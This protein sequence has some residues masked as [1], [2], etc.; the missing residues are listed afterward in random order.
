MILVV[1]GAG[2]I[3][4]HV[5]KLLNE[6]SYETVVYDSLI[7]GHRRFAKWGEMGLGDLGSREQLRLCFE[8]YPIEAV[9][10]FGGFTYVGESVSDPA[11]YYRNNLINTF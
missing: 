5:N 4:A 6:R 2:Y 3:G 9:M 1:G 7:Y 10:H 8:K 11:K